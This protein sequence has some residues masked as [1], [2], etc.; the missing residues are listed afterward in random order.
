MGNYSDV[1][2]ALSQHLLSMA[3][4]PTVAWDG[5]DFAP[6]LGSAYIKPQLLPAEPYQAELGA[7][8]LNYLPGIYQISVCTPGGLGVGRTLQLVDAVA[9]HFKRGTK[10]AYGSVNITIKSAFPAPMIEGADWNVTPISILFF[11]LAPN[12]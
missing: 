10:L 6:V 4:L 8:G 7:N 1:R 9:S 12:S 5:T 2:S 3:N 11:A